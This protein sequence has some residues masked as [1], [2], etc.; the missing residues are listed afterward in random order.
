M[1]DIGRDHSAGPGAEP[2]GLRL[3][4]RL[5]TALLV[6]MILGIAAIVVLVATR[7]PARVS[8]PKL[9]AAFSAPAGESVT[10]IS[11]SG[12]LTLVV[13]RDGSGTQ[14]IHLLDPETGAIRQTTTV[15]P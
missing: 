2:A 9:P 12:G 11:L 15:A 13:T 14:R 6:V 5:V 4:R 1:S 7:L 3:L 8:L 10:G